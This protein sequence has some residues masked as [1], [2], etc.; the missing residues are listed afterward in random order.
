VDYSRYCPS[1]CSHVN[2]EINVICVPV[3]M[4][5]KVWDAADAAAEA[6]DTAAAIAAAGGTPLESG[7]APSPST[8]PLFAP[9]PALAAPPPINVAALGFEPSL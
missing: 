7:F 8:Q 1:Y 6:A 2:N 5:N 9:A 3:A 4:A